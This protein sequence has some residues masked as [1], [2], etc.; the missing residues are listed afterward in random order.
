VHIPDGYLSPQTCAVGFAVAVPV[1]AVASQR[2]SK[3]VKTRNVPLLALLSALSFLIMMFNIPVPDG[4][5]AH[6]VGGVLVAVV[7][8]PWAAVIAVSVA[9]LFQA[10]LF[11]DGGVLAYGANVVNLAIIMPFLGY[12]VYRLVAGK[13]PLTARR[14]VIAAAAG[15]YVGINA[16]ALATAIEFGIQPALFQTASGAP[17]YS[18]YGLA[19]TIPAMMLAHVTVAGAAEAILTGGVLAYLARTDVARL[20]PNHPGIPVTADDAPAPRSGRVSPG[21][22]AVAFM[23]VMVLLTPLG[24][25]A[26]GGAFGEDDPSDLNPADLGLS[27]IPEG[28]VRYNGFWS[29]TLL[30]GYG[31]ADGEHAN[32][33]YIL[34]ALVGIAVVGLFIFG[35]GKLTQSVLSR[36]ATP[37]GREAEAGLAGPAGGTADAVPDRR[38]ASRA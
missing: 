3:V 8:G 25:L 13:S 37:G 6:A 21:R 33:A 38:D 11:G 36:R 19:E 15:G 23:A 22:V 7:L 24:L 12:A 30:G 34:S 10:L 20:V 4:T 5:S 35:I 28:L 26:P 32:L 1:W 16:A 9:L 17:L 31:F 29:H 27:A 14:R 18:P 2:V